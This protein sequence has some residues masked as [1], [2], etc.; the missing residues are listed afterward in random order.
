M[1]DY[2]SVVRLTPPLDIEGVRRF[3]LLACADLYGV[4]WLR[5]FLDA[6]GERMLCWY[7]AP[8]AEAV[9]FVLRQQGSTEAAV[10][11]A[12][13]N[14]DTG[15]DAVDRDLVVVEF[16]AETLAAE[17]LESTKATVLAA[18]EARGHAVRYVF[19]AKNA[20][21]LVCLIEGQITSPVIECL[22]AAGVTAGAVWSSIELDPSPPKLFRSRGAGR[23]QSDAACE[24]EARASL[25]VSMSG[26]P[27][28]DEL[29]EGAFDAVIVGAGFSGICALERLLR[30]G[31]AVQVYEA[32]HDVGGVWHFNRYPGARV[33]SESYTYG[34]SFSEEV[35][36]EWRWRELFAAQPEVESYLHFVVDRLRLRQHMRFD[37]R[38]VSA[39]YDEA[40]NRWRLETHTGERATARYLIAATGSLSAAQFPDYPGIADFAGE[41]HH[42]ARWPAGG[43]DLG[44]RRVG[45]IGT[46]ASGVQ[47]IQTIA[48]T[49]RE[50]T[51][52]Q[53]TPTFCIPQRNRELSEQERR[54]IER[55]F[56]DILVACQTSYGGFIHDFDP[57]PGLMLSAE[58]REAKFEVLWR[59][60]GFAFWLGNFAD[61]LM[62]SEVN[63]H[64]GEFLRKK[65]RAR[66][67]DP[68]VARKLLPDHPFG[69]KRV[70]LENGYYEVYNRNNVHLV[71]LRETPIERITPV[72]I[73]T[74]REEYLLDVIVYATGFDAG[75]G[76]LTRMDIRGEGGLALAEKWQQGPKTYLGLLVSGFPNLF[77]VNGPQN[78]AALC[79]AGRCVEQNVDWI[80]RCIEYLRGHGLTHIAPTVAAE[81]E[82]TAH[83][84][85]VAEATV[86]GRM[87][88]SWF[89]GANTPGKARRASIYA[90][91][92]LKYRLQC[93]DVALA[94]YV[95]CTF[96]R[97]PRHYSD[98]R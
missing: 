56:S 69:T 4:N 53:R 59:K 41:S 32:G 48:D 34:F 5:G 87:K 36:R 98:R 12:E 24:D 1:S 8:D 37:T 67:H 61:L 9:R 58:A 65:I 75:T 47:L 84:E 68:E 49:V 50:L 15:G 97:N 85:D 78:A 16:P 19:T 28:A 33:D 88:Q 95:G 25:G 54:E 42:T 51:V 35:L 39:T 64:A 3:A 63:A 92:A 71:D 89:F 30:M 40:G 38:I 6:G 82:W 55:N 62:N 66:L 13:V 91:G 74:S 90:A 46:G 21:H 72:G 57:Q 73:Q 11:P 60:P 18:L 10:R 81:N 94:G 70:P 77:I 29:G 22:Q 96:G 23:A 7:Q 93:E 86:L 17:G 27:L 83:V 76:A 80:A 44:G 20:A 26:E 43:V 2:F 45:I 52:F 31:M 14:G 79:N